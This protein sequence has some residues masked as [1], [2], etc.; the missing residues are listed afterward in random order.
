MKTT[1]NLANFTLTLLGIGNQTEADGNDVVACTVTCVDRLR[2]SNISL[3]NREVELGGSGGWESVL[4]SD[5]GPLVKRC[6]MP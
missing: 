1:Q 3:A 2:A 4:F 6:A 5:S